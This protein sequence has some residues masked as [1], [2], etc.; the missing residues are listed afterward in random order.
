MLHEPR[1]WRT[2]EKIAAVET[3]SSVEW[4]HWRAYLTCHLQA[5]HVTLH[6]IPAKYTKHCLNILYEQ[7][8]EFRHRKNFLVPH[9]VGRYHLWGGEMFLPTPN[10]HGMSLKLCYLFSNSHTCHLFH[11]SLIFIALQFLLWISANLI[12]SKITF[13]PQIISFVTVFNFYTVNHKKGGSTF[14]IITLGNIDRFLSFLHCC[15][16]E[17]FFLLMYEKMSTSPK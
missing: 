15:K 17:E 7:T 6:S 9:E 1:E 4:I 10:Y 11:L 8:E 16:E 3:T 13:S 14:V 2:T 12:T 5:H